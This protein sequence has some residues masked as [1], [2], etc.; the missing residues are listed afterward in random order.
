MTSI[1]VFSKPKEIERRVS[2]RHKIQ[3][4]TDHNNVSVIKVEQL[5]VFKETIAVYCENYTDNL[6]IQLIRN[7]EFPNQESIPTCHC[8][9]SL[10]I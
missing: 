5:V 6:K 7:A 9:Q 10:I 3:Y 4:I 8:F 2:I 1:L